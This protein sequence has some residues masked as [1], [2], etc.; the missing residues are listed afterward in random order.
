MEADLMVTAYQEDMTTEYFT[1]DSGY[2]T[3]WNITVP[4]GES[5]VY[6]KIAGYSGYDSGTFG[7][8]VD[9]AP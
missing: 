1:G 7:I 9:S 2:F 6:I 4:V 8:K 3:P 5:T